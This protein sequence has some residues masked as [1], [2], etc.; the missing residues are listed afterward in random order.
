MRAC[1]ATTEWIDTQGE[2]GE[3]YRGR[4]RGVLRMGETRGT[5]TEIKV[6]VSA[7]LALPRALFDCA[8][9]TVVETLMSSHLRKHTPARAVAF[10]APRARKGRNKST[11]TAVTCTSSSLQVLEP[12]DRPTERTGFGKTYDTTRKH[13]TRKCHAKARTHPAG[14]S[15][16]WPQLRVL[17]P[18]DAEGVPYKKADQPNQ[19]TNTGSHGGGVYS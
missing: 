14:C 4:G 11:H 17:P 2:P 13:V 8:L 3:G 9:E 5:R 15:P 19:D 1:T 6:A 10:V 7:S 16:P 12:S 18:P